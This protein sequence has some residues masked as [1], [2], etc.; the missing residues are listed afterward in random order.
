MPKTTIILQARTNSTRLPGKV[1]KK[2][3]DLP[4]ILFQ[5][6]R[7]N[8]AKLVDEIIVATSNTK[9]MMNL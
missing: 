3:G 6:E 8:K 5:L 7:L 4:M 1:L 9:K 2:V